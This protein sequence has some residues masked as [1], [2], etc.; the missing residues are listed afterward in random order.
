MT[1]NY[2]TKTIETSSLAVPEQVSVAMAEIAE[3]MR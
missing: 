1:K 3:D 2:Q